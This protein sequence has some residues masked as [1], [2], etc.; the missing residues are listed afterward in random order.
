MLKTTEA[1]AKNLFPWVILATFI[2]GVIL[3]SPWSGGFELKNALHKLGEALVIAAI[4]A[5]VVDRYVKDK[6]VAEV[7]RDVLSYSVGHAI[8]KEIQQEIRHLLRLPFVRQDFELIFSLKEVPNHPGFVAIVMQTSFR[9]INLTDVSQ[10]Y[11]FCSSIEK[12]LFPEVGENKLLSIVVNGPHSF[13]LRA[14]ELAV[15]SESSGHFIEYRNSLVIPKSSA[16]PVFVWTER[17][18]IYKENFTHV[19][20]I[21][22]PTL[23]V[24]VISEFPEDFQVGVHF[25]V[26]GEP[27]CIP[28][29]HPKKF[30]HGGVFLPGHHVRMTWR[31]SPPQNIREAGE[32]NRQPQ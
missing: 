4:L 25:A 5:V 2:I 13:T 1:K 15:K 6:L 21:L 29:Y 11:P 30:V 28:E 16:E 27:Q 9:I 32:E 20:D 17:V 12:T 8:P 10:E 31:R 23:G 3:V 24:T 7:A 22:A 19:L 14:D 26:R 18:A